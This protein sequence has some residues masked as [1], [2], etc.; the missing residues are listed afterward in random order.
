MNYIRVLFIACNYFLVVL[1][2]YQLYY[3]D[4]FVPILGIFVADT[5]VLW[6]WL[7]SVKYNE[8]LSALLKDYK[9]GRYCVE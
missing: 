1:G 4:W 3:G 8:R 6:L 2:C 9:E 5:S 7:V